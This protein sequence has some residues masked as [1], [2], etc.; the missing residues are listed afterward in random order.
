VRDKK[1]FNRAVVRLAA[2]FT[3]IGLFV[4]M[5]FSVTIYNV[6]TQGINRP[7]PLSEEGKTQIVSNVE[8]LIQERARSTEREI[9]V[10]L[11]TLNVVVVSI[12]V[13]VGM[14]FARQVLKPVY[15]AYE[16][17]SRFV[18]DASHE[19]RTP[20]TAIMMENEVLLRDS[21]ATKEDLKTQVQS[22]LEEARKLQSLTNYLLTLSKAESADLTDVSLKAAINQAVKNFAPAAK[23]KKITV[24]T[25]V[26]QKTVKAE[27]NALVSLIGILLENAIKYSPGGSTIRVEANHDKIKVIDEGCGIAKKDLEHIF[28]RFYRAEKS[29]TSEGFGLGLSLAKNLAEKMNLK[30]TAENNPKK[31]ATFTIIA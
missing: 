3:G 11:V 24:K 28:D 9:F 21:S 20:L 31:G 14:F 17:Q 30:L 13:V 19:L 1:L 18:S 22:N 16:D 6:A 2:I 26:K 25:S 29:R 27:E 15:K 7:Q 4:C 5:L 10:G 23:A 12:G 8:I